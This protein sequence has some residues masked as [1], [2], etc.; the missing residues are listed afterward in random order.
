MDFWTALAPYAPLGI[1][2]A[3]LS[4]ALT[5]LLTGK[6]VTR[7][8]LQDLRSDRDAQLTDKNSQVETWRESYIASESARLLQAQQLGELLTQVNA[9]SAQGRTVEHLITELQ[10]L[11]REQRRT[12]QGGLA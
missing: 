12:A 9:L 8:Q 4:L 5:L 3:A 6:L 2:G 7:A 11:A 10:A 1:M